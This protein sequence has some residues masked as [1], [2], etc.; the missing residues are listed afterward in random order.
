M[1]LLKYL[2]K[3]YLI[4]KVNRKAFLRLLKSTE[5]RITH[6]KQQSTNNNKTK[7]NTNLL[8]VFLG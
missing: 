7:D 5:I 3:K 8:D 4:G 1:G 6:I 2:L